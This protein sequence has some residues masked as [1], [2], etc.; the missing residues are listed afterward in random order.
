M[1]AHQATCAPSAL[2]YERFG[3]AMRAHQAT[4][5]P[6]A[7][8]YERFGAAMRAHGNSLSEAGA[9]ESRG[10]I[11]GPRRAFSEVGLLPSRAL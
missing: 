3:A 10:P 11:C 2:R 5:A 7:L 8:R 4:C 1:R 9:R 6:L